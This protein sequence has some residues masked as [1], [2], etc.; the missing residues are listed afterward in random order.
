VNAP[1]E[2]PVASVGRRMRG[3]LLHQSASLLTSIGSYLVI[4]RLVDPAEYGRAAVALALWGVCAI[5]LE[6]TGHLLMRYGPVELGRS[7]SLRVSISTRLVFALPPLLV[8]L[9]GAPIYLVLARGWPM[10]LALLT[11]PW[12]LLTTAS[13]VAQWSGVAAQR[14]GPLATGSALNRAAPVMMVLLLTAR[15]VPV[16]GEALVVATLVGLAIGAAI[17]LVALRRLIGIERPDPTLLRSMWRYCLPALLAMPCGAAISFADPLVLERWVSHADL[18]RYQLAYAVISVFG[19]LGASLNS[20]MS[21]ELVRASATGDRRAIEL[22]RTRDQP[23]FAILLGLG[24][25]GAACVAA[26][27]VALFL[28]ARFAGAGEVVAI[29]T[30]AGGFM[31]GVWS[32]HPLVTVTDSVWALQICSALGAATNLLLDLAWAPR[33]GTTGVAL[34]NVAAWALQFVALALLLRRRIGTRRIALAVL[35]PSGAAVLLLLLGGAPA[36]LRVAVGLSLLAG[37]A[38]AAA[39]IYRARF[40]RAPRG[41]G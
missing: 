6:G 29:L 11:I 2:A 32:L 24:T 18:G 36:W 40:R 5:P 8:L 10:W 31:V 7:G 21:P 22:Y 33:G 39:K 41:D 15:H 38:I 35:P 28:P 19:M 34:A 23:R 17:P 26:P 37:C 9:P 14:F 3:S 20:V 30:V 25:F 4:G 1:A 27:L 13:S 12:L 16:H